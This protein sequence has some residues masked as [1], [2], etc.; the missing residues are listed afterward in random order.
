M[1]QKNTSMQH[2]QKL[3][4]DTEQN[5]DYLIKSQQKNG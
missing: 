1:I 3:K 5:K 2:H 4:K